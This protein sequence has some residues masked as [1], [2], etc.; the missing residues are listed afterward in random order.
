MLGASGGAS[1]SWGAWLRR[2]APSSLRT[3]AL[4][5]RGT[6]S[7]KKEAELAQWRV[8]SVDDHP[9]FREGLAAALNL[10]DAFTVVGQA[11]CADGA[12]AEAGRSRA[13][14]W[15]SWTSGCP[16]RSGL[17]A[18]RRI[19]CAHPEAAG[20]GHDD[21]RGRRQPAGRRAR[22]GPWLSAQGRG[23]GRGPARLHTVARRRRR[24]QPADGGA[25]RGAAGASGSASA[26]QA[27]PTLTGPGTGGAGP[28]G[29]RSRLPADRPAAGGHRQDRT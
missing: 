6:S 16:G 23:P 2:R 13:R 4:T 27:F 29:G 14:I 22:G 15:W 8:L 1:P 20:A 25:A 21:V 12:I 26:K 24:L 11:A 19:L 28:A 18:T 9:L 3:L 7:K 5:G 17:E 10:D